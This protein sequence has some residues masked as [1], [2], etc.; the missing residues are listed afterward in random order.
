MTGPTY[1]AMA[2]VLR[3]LLWPDEKFVHIFQLASLFQGPDTE[4]RVNR[5]ASPECEC[6]RH[7]GVID[8]VLVAKPPAP[9]NA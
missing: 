4:M 2:Q 8:R 9:P 7:A 1:S 6:T 3:N 5:A